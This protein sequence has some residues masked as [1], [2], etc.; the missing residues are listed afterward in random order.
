VLG[1]RSRRIRVAYVSGWAMLDNAR[2][3]TGAEELIPYSSHADFQE[4]MDLVRASGAREIDVVHGYT[5]AFAR[6]LTIEGWVARAGE[7]QER[8]GVH[9]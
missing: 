8:S 9:G 1:M 5:E 7:R 3:R 2:A 6:I 4:L